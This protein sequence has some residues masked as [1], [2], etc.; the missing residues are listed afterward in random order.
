MAEPFRSREG[1]Q[2]SHVRPRVIAEHWPQATVV[3]KLKVREARTWRAPRPVERRN[4]HDAVRAP[5][6]TKT[7]VGHI[8]RKPNLRDHAQ[9]VAAPPGRLTSLR[10]IDDPERAGGTW[11]GRYV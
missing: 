9:A 6:T 10:V 5:Q 3:L 2:V 7:H 11:I 4:Q 8:L 1:G